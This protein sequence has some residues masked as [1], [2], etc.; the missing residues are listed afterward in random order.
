MMTYIVM[1]DI[2]LELL[3]AGR[4][5]RGMI[6]WCFAM[7]KS[8]IGLHLWTECDTLSTFAGQG[9]MKALKILLHDQSFIE[10]F[11][12]LGTSENITNDV[13]CIIQEFVCQL[14]CRNTKV[15]KVNELR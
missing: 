7:D 10:V 14:Y 6:P 4:C 1:V 11:A 3:H 2:L 5:I 13:F 15:T 8:L 12:S 9:K